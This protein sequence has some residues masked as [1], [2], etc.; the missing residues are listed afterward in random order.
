MRRCG[1][2]D[3]DL[4]LTEF[5]VVNGAIQRRCKSCQ[6][7]SVS[8]WRRANRERHNQN[9]RRWASL[10]PEKIKQ[11]NRRCHAEHGHKCVAKK[12]AWSAAN[13]DKC[14]ESER[15]W[16]QK[17]GSRAIT[18]KKSAEWR[19]A[20]PEATAARERAYRQR[21][22]HKVCF[23]AKTRRARKR[24]ASVVDLTAAQWAAIQAAFD[25]RCAYCGKRRKD[26]LTQDHITPLSKGG[27]HTASNIVP[28]CA[29][30]NSTKHT[31]PP[32]APVQP[33]LLP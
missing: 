17:P 5:Y 33:L 32:L 15:K 28:A 9:A 31:G 20:H 22:P 4:P 23:F 13:R 19:A 11:T 12:S 27:G 24:N 26:K 16:R 14:R 10:N 29:S 21:N 8:E 30:C 25:H 18:N 7:S 3:M 1:K 6:K 2:C